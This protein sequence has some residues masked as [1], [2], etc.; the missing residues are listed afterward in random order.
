MPLNVKVTIS[1]DDGKSISK[2]FT[3]SNDYL[4]TVDDDP[5]TYK[6][7]LEDAMGIMRDI[8]DNIEG[9]FILDES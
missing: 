9:E 3:I 5:E 1:D 7:T 8:S 4:C 2:D 6:P